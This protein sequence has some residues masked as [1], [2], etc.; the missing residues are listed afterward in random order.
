MKNSVLSPEVRINSYS[1][2]DQCILMNGV[3]VG[4]HARLRSV[5]VDKYVRIPPGI[6]IGY[7]PEEDRRRFTVTDSGVIRIVPRR[8]QWLITQR[9]LCSPMGRCEFRGTSSLKM[10]REKIS[11]CQAARP[12][13]FAVAVIRRTSHSATAATHVTGFNRS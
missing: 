13:V 6:E 7:N 8:N 9:Y 12:L 4:R 2:I 3:D 1:E 5:I 10:D 11:I